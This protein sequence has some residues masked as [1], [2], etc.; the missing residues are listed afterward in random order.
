MSIASLTEEL[1]KLSIS[2]E[3]FEEKTELNQ[4]LNLDHVE[5][6]DEARMTLKDEIGSERR[7]I[8]E[9]INKM[10]DPNLNMTKLSTPFY[11]IRSPAKPKEEIK[12][13]SI[14]DLSHQ[15]NN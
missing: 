14:T 15:D 2:A 1:N 10:I 6:S 4:E 11:H 9:K 12:K 7:L 3:I 13:P 8:T 5:K